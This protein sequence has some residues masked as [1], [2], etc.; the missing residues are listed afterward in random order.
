MTTQAEDVTTNNSL[1]TVKW[2]VAIAILIAA[3]V[4]NRYA[5]ELLPQLSSWVRIVALVVLA[6][7]ALAIT[8]TTTQGQSFIK[9]LKEAQ[10]EARR[11]VW[12]TKD[13]TMQTTMIV[14]AVVVVMSLLLWGI[15][16]LFGWMI[17][18]VIG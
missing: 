15:D 7:G 4:G 10:V 1:N 8:F 12:P 9:L 2:V 11:I 6:V 18:A 3:T 14:C 17:S 16:T 13:E 5:P